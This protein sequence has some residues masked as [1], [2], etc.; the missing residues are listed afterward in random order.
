MD[1]MEQPFE[2]A[3]IASLVLVVLLNT[4]HVLTLMEA[5]TDEEDADIVDAVPFVLDGS[6]LL[7]A[8]GVS[9]ATL[10]H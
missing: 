9:R 3:S 6:T 4:Q 2:M 10:H 7:D 5:T 8:E 1:S